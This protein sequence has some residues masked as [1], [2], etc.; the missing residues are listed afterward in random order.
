[1]TK[2]RYL[3]VDGCK[4]GWFFV[5]IGPENEAEFG[6][7]ESIDP[8]FQAYSDAKYIL[9][10]IPI[11]LPSEAREIRSCD[12][13]A[14]KVLKPKRHNSV[15]SPPCREALPVSTYEAACRINKK[16]TGRKISRQA[17]H[18][19]QKIREVDN[20]LNRNFEARKIIRETHP[21]VCFWA[22]AGSKPMDHYKKTPEGLK[23]RLGLLKKHF[24]RASAIYKAALDRYLRKEVGR[25]D[26][27][28]ALTVAVTASQLDGKYEATLPQ[29]PEKDTLGLPMEMV[30]A[31]PSDMPGSESLS[32][33]QNMPDTIIDLIR[34]SGS[35][36]RVF[37]ATEYFNET[38]MLRLVLDW[39]S[40][41]HV[42]DHPLLMTK[43]CQ[44]FSEGLIPSRFFP[45]SRKDPLGE[46][47]T[48]A[49]G[50]VGHFEV[51]EGG[52]TDVRLTPNATHL[53]CV[54]AKMFSRLSSGVKNARYFNQ[55]ARYVACMAELMHR[56]N[57]KPGEMKHL[58]FFIFAPGEQIDAGIFSTQSSPDN[59]DEM[60][61][62]RVSEYNGENDSWYHKWFLP[63][64][65][66]VDIQCLSWES[67]ANTI[68]IDDPYF[69]NQIQTFYLNCLEYNRP[70]KK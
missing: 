25:D 69:G 37:P 59:I 5:V 27:L 64:L 31:M 70:T 36:Q 9:I 4:A 35:D 40:K 56:A 21:E 47:W 46:S 34:L 14:R 8:L 20:L 6:V 33:S 32:Q 63:T 16:I 61:K 42:S 38:W 28:D 43:D 12:T 41:N 7:F 30:Y 44:W 15:F 53:A 24:S 39:F 67:I 66:N 62:R 55:A 10:D 49:D 3:G 68:L 19:S 57:L 22:L 50:I 52:R 51:G 48:H 18:V 23:E 1:M 58:A 17:Y 54:E 13:E 2:N 11:G 45:R 26:I 29:Y 60:V 65:K